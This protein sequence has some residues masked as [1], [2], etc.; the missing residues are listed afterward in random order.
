MSEGA[1]RPGNN[2]QLCSFGS[3]RAGSQ[4]RFTTVHSGIA[5]GRPAG[6]CLRISSVGS[7]LCYLVRRLE[8]PDHNSSSSGA[9]VGA[10]PGGAGRRH[11]SL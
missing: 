4:P 9:V 10:R 5:E 2:R 11:L 3:L 8:G 1:D 6:C 7:G